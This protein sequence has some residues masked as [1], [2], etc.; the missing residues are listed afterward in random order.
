MAEQSRIEAFI[1]EALDRQVEGGH[2]ALWDCLALVGLTA[3]NQGHNGAYLYK[4][5]LEKTPADSRHLLWRRYIDA[6]SEMLIIVGMP[7]TLNALY[8]MM[9]LVDRGDLAYVKKTDWE[10]DNSARGWEYARLTHGDGW[11]ESFKAASA[12]APDVA[13]IA[14][15][16]SMQN[17]LSDYSVH[18]GQAT[19]A[20]L[21]TVLIAMNCPVQA[22]WHAKGFIRHGGD[23]NSLVHIAEFAKK[24]VVATGNSLPA[25]FPTVEAMLEEP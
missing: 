16:V 11:P 21:V 7:K 3:V 6:L 13:H 9:P 23:K 5:A 10:A 18:D 24:I 8:A 14:M 2:H 20:L 25:D 19:M 4:S 22:S 1:N 12:Y 17:L 15:D